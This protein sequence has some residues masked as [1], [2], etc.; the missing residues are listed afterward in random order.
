M[1][2]KSAAGWLL[3]SSKSYLISLN[4]HKS[5]GIFVSSEQELRQ[6]LRVSVAL[7]CLMHHRYHLWSADD[8]PLSGPCLWLT[9]DYTWNITKYLDKSFLSF[10]IIIFI[11]LPILVQSLLFLSSLAAKRRIHIPYLPLD[12]SKKSRFSTAVE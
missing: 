2:I 6:S 9:S 10:W 3:H 7:S 1:L 8:G 5:V 11:S 4:K 12:K